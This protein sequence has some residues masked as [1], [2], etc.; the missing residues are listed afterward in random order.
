[1][2]AQTLAYLLPTLSLA[3][4]RAEAEVEA[5]ATAAATLSRWAMALC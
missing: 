4:A 5:A 1:M 2:P 3:I